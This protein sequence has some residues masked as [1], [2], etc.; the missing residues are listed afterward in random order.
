MSIELLINEYKEVVLKESSASL[1][2]CELLYKIQSEMLA[3][4]DGNTHNKFY[5]KAIA[6]FRKET[7]L[8]KA[9]F[10]EDVAVGKFLS[11]DRSSGRLNS[12]RSMTK[13]QIYKQYCAPPKPKLVKDTGPK[14]NYKNEYNKL[15][16]EN[17]ALKQKHEYM[18]E[19]LGIFIKKHE[20]LQE[21]YQALKEKLD[22]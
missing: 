14:I 20:A 21:R 8:S 11:I 12:T 6:K 3:Q 13:K 7:G 2:S 15:T 10:N 5:Q 19:Q 4:V 16:E 22:S 17:Q 18:K 1:D 9:Q